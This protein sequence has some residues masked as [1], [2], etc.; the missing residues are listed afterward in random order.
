M[1]QGKQ[2]ST[3]DLQI[4]LSDCKVPFEWESAAAAAAATA[5]RPTGGQG[6]MARSGSGSGSDLMVSDDEEDDTGWEPNPSAHRRTSARQAA[7]QQQ[8]QQEQQEALPAWDPST[9]MWGP[10]L[11]GAPPPLAAPLPA[12]GQLPPG[13]MEALSLAPPS[14]SA[15]PVRPTARPA[16]AGRIE[17]LQRSLMPAQQ[18]MPLQGD[19]LASLLASFSSVPASDRQQMALLLKQL[20]DLL[21]QQSRAAAVQA[22]VARLQQ[23]P[24]GAAAL[25]SLLQQVH[26]GGTGGATA[27]N[28][29]PAEVDPLQPTPFSLPRANSA[30]A[31]VPPPPPPH[32]NVLAALLGAA[33]GALPQPGSSA[34]ALGS[35][36]SAPPP[37]PP[38]AQV[39]LNLLGAAS[40]SGSLPPSLNGSLKGE[41]L[42]LPDHLAAQLAAAQHEAAQAVEAPQ[43]QEQEFKLSA[44]A[45]EQAVPAE[46][47]TA[48]APAAAQ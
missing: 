28:A 45:A 36:A 44:F 21:D 27:G 3:A 35:Q 1:Q 23:P 19:P 48:E 25:A 4:I 37:G 31:A 7:Q 38:P 10:N 46:I 14:A 9:L 20:A 39:L 47:A 26:G 40:A 5:D 42:A 13:L 32:S 33:S 17:Q 43:Q 29:L 16:D 41:L 15:P 22:L 8:Q 2:V 6:R 12:Q 11:G 24:P 34:P 18:S 30:P